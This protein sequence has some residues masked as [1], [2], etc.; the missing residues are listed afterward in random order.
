MNV[1][2]ITRPSRFHCGYAVG[3]AFLATFA[4]AGAHDLRTLIQRQPDD[5][6]AVA[7]SFFMPV[8]VETESG[9]TSDTG[10]R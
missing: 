1:S 8:Q 5:H 4:S 6:A 10:M 7:E 2:N 3:A 9:T